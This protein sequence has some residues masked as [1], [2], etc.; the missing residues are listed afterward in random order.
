VAQVVPAVT[1]SDAGGGEVE[2]RHPDGVPHQPDGGKVENQ[3]EVNASISSASART[4]FVND[5]TVI[6]LGEI[7]EEPGALIDLRTQGSPPVDIRFYNI[8][9]Y[10]YEYERRGEDE[11]KRPAT[12]SAASATAR[13]APPQVSAYASAHHISSN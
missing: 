7:L 11:R 12:S 6:S 4:E 9:K 8:A 2:N 1:P 10:Y 13:A 5:S 3:V